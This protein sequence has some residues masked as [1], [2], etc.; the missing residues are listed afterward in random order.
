MDSFHGIYAP[1]LPEIRPRAQYLSARN[2]R[3]HNFF[4]VLALDPFRW[5]RAAEAA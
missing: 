4:T 5:G 3:Y 1:G 2:F